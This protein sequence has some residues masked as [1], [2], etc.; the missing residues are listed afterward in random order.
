MVNLVII[1]HV[2]INEESSPYGRARSLGG[3][4]YGCARGASVLTPERVGLVSVVGDG[5]D[6]GTLRRLGINMRGVRIMDGPS[7]HFQIVQHANGERSSNV[8]LGLAERVF[9]NAFPE[10]YASADHVHI[11]TAPPS[12]QLEWLQFLRKLPGHRTISCDAF[13]HYAWLDPTGSR[14]ALVNCDLRFLNDA[15][16]RMLFADDALPRPAIIKH[17]AEGASFLEKDHTWHSS[18]DPVTAV[19]TTHAGEIVAGVF[20]AL[21]AE[22]LNTTTAL[23]LAVRAATAKVTEFGVDGDRLLVALAEIRAEVG[24]GG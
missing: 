11:C 24:A 17:G 3:A 21:R 9:L 22:G 14:S 5:F 23:R 1:G 20:L 8:D 4:G 15:E 7:A 12:Q 18:A 6:S 16:R 2:G 19:D 13:E 10:E